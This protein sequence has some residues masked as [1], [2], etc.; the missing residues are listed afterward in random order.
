MGALRRKIGFGPRLLLAQSL[1]VLV[2]SIT[3]LGVALFLAPGL[4]RTHLEQTAGPVSTEVTE[5]LQV[6]FTKAML[7]SLLIGV[8]AAAMT[9]LAVSWYITRRVVDPITAMAQAAAAV[10]GGHYDARVTESGL[11]SEFDA[12]GRSFNQMARDLAATERTRAQV[13]RDLA[14]ELRTPLTT[15]RGY[16]EALADGVLPADRETFATIEAELSRVQ[17]LIDDLSRVAAAEEGSAMLQRRAIQATDLLTSAIAAAAP[18]FSRAGVTLSLEPPDECMVLVDPDRL[19]EVLT[20]L[21]NNALRHTPQGGKVTLGAVNEGQTVRLTVTDTGEGIT[22]EHLP[23]VFERFY[24]VDSHHPHEHGGSGIGLAITRALV[25]A[26]NGHVQ[27]HS[28]GPGK[29]STFTITLPAS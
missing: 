23:R 6:A 1:V 14:H 7:T 16:H 25:Q 15:I 28:A 27:A 10:A 9:G 2:G 24:R 8:L 19:Q 13:L 11:G 4:F 20:N 3:L 18:N 5:H 21:L 29:G 26:H 17:R 12:V 22:A